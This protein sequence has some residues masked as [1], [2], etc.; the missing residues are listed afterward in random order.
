[1]F[2]FISLKVNKSLFCKFVR[3]MRY[4]YL[5]MFDIQYLPTLILSK[6][7]CTVFGVIFLHLAD[8]QFHFQKIMTQ[9]PICDCY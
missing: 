9:G 8:V 3:D 2:S 6:M 4:F 1:M 7:L 5:P